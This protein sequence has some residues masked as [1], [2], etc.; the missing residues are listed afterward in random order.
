MPPRWPERRR[1]AHPSLSSARP[2]DE[3]RSLRFGRAAA[4]SARS[5]VFSIPGVRVNSPRH[6]FVLDLRLLAAHVGLSGRTSGFWARLG[7][8]A[9]C[10]SIFDETVAENTKVHPE[11]HVGR[12]RTPFTG[13][14]APPER[15]VPTPRPPS[16]TRS[17]LQ[18][19][20][21]A[22]LHPEAGR[23]AVA[24]LCVGLPARA[25]HCR[26]AQTPS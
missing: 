21:P 22:P 13:R 7:F 17:P 3:C 24:P 6:A 2:P 11:R 20:T 23:L 9:C 12:R 19:G 16:T 14:R 15:H 4:V 10:L 18:P 5:V 26:S 25:R 8:W 1:G